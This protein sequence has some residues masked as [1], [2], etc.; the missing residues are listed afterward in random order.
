MRDRHGK[1]RKNSIR[2]GQG[3]GCAA[4][5]RSPEAPLLFVRAGRV[6]VP[7]SDGQDI[8]GRKKGDVE[9]PTGAGL[10]R[11][12]GIRWQ[13]LLCGCGGRVGRAVRVRDRQEHLIRGKGDTE[14]PECMREGRA[15]GVL[16]AGK[17]QG[18]CGREHQ[19]RCGRGRES[20]GRAVL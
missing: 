3:V 9:K 15:A 8:V 1:R 20:A 7:G 2:S 5:D 13:G 18:R 4:G 6:A 12:W 10:G 17:R 16:E 14:G 19:G 11:A